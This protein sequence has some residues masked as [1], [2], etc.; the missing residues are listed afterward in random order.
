MKSLYFLLL[1]FAAFS[2]FAQTSTEFSIEK[3]QSKNQGISAL[4]PGK[5][6]NGNV[7][8][9]IPYA[10]NQ[11]LIVWQGTSTEN[12]KHAKYL[13]CEIWHENNFSAV[14]NLEFYR[15]ENS[16][17]GI[18]AQSGSVA[19]DTEGMPRMSAKIGVL[20]KLKTKVIFP[21]GYLNG[22]EIFMDRFPRQLKG[23]V[24]GNRMKPEDIAKV[25]VRFGPYQEPYFKPQFEVAAVYLTE[26]LPEPYP[27]PEKP[28]VDEL[29]QWTA[30]DWP[31]KTKNENE[32]TKML[33][34]QFTGSD[35]SS[36]PKNRSKYGGWKEKQ[37]EA[38]G[39]FRTH[40]DGKRWWLVD[41]EG[42]AFVSV[43]VDCIRDNVS[44][45]ISGQEN[46]FKWLPDSTDELYRDAYSARGE[47][48]MADF[49]RI[50]L[51]RTFGE[52]WRENWEKITTSQIRELGINTIGNWSDIEYARNAGVPY[53]LPLS[54]F[55]SAKVQLYRDF[56]DV[57]SDEYAENAKIFA[58]QLNDFKNDRWL[59]GYFLRNEPHW[60]F[61]A[62]DI[63]FE[64][65]GTQQSSA[66]KKEFATWLS[67]RYSSIGEFNKSWKL[68]LNNFNE[69]TMQVF[70]EYPS[71][72]SK[73]D[74]MVFSEVL[75]A[76]YV[77]VPCDEVEKVDPNHLNLGMRYAWISSGFTVQ[78]RRTI[79]C[80]F[81]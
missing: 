71:E 17:A 10:E 25:V 63:A 35:V 64:M 4:K 78:S 47:F 50:N 23:T 69:I 58:Q 55:P 70:D 21:L 33:N 79:R 52:K 56:P 68:N 14:V 65:F 72:N 48:V 20:P 2:C 62:N 75:V 27:A 8:E 34:E 15:K 5:G 45:L 3:I 73:K 81:D 66:S 30:K 6:F 44:G 12:W 29:G 26:E 42:Y 7:L 9:V 49:Y 28:V 22:Q 18:I 53:V 77:N 41:P 24:L 1:I 16:S 59:I 19:G 51:M 36:I 32:L 46:L 57:F 67:E 31:G 11:S 60:A 43:G 13:V 54:N 61:G 80:F 39:F 37:F 74:F 38:T 40:N 76:K